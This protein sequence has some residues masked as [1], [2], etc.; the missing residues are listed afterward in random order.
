MQKSTSELSLAVKQLFKNQGEEPPDKN[1]LANTEQEK[2]GNMF[3]CT[4]GRKEPTQ[5]ELQEYAQYETCQRLLET[6]KI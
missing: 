2:I 1:R 6:R 4:H 5:E 3:L